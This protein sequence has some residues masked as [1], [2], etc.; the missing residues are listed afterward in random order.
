MQTAVKNKIT[1]HNTVGKLEAIKMELTDQTL[2]EQENNLIRTITE[3][4]EENINKILTLEEANLP[5]F[6]EIKD[7]WS[8]A[9]TR[10]HELETMTQMMKT[11][12][13]ALKDARNKITREIT[14]NT[15]T[16]SEDPPTAQE[17]GKI[18]TTMIK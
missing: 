8:M 13:R 16:T 1:S 5:K 4:V 14:T 2:T 10:I 9:T 6:E 3:Q 12:K 11:W 17:D 15:R 18:K 7:E